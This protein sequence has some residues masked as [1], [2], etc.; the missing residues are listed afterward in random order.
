MRV[1]LLVLLI[2]LTPVRSWAADAMAIQMGMQSTAQIS[3]QQAAME[4]PQMHPDDCMHGQETTKVAGIA[5][6]C[7]TCAS[8]QACF[9]IALVSPAHAVTSKPF[10]H[11]LPVWTT[12]FF[13]SAERMLGQKPPIS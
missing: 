11:H 6:H 4:P 13:T 5:D 8:C 9:T 12:A 7:A 1:F 2:A 10:I 3:S